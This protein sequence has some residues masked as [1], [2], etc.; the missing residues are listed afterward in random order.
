MGIAHFIKNDMSVYN[1][2]II[3]GDTLQQIK[4]PINEVKSD[5]MLNAFIVQEIKL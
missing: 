2:H 4:S 5:W 3:F 1:F